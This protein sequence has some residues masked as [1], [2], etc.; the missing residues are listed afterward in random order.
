M[1]RFEKFCYKHEHWG[2]KN[3][4]LFVVLC[5]GLVY[6]LS[7]ALPELPGFIAFDAG[8][9]AQGQVW[10]IITFVFIPPTDNPLFLIFALFFY[11][12]IGSLLEREWGRLKFTIFYAT[13]MLGTALCSL[14][15]RIP[16]DPFYLNM[17]MLLAAGTV[18][19][20]L[21]ITLYF[22]IPIKL[23][24][25]AVADAVIFFV[26]PLLETLRFG[27]SRFLL[28][29]FLALLNYLLFF[30]GHFIRLVRRDAKH[31]GNVVNFKQEV[32]RAKQKPAHTGHTHQ[33]VVCGVTDADPGVEFRYCSLCA[34]YECYCTEHIFTH[35]HIKE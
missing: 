22:I 28:I 26:I 14:V 19:P 29:P 23:K 35:E 1:N 25:L 34:H 24:W 4:M 21:R 3:L 10:R 32:R 17:S 12:W 18:F 30:S 16:A 31:H 11:Y 6:V 27:L 15:A 5:T 8:M 9:I 20:D 33:C 2:L 7:L 13:G